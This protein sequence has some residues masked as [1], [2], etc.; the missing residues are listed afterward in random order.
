[1]KTR[2]ARVGGAGSPGFENRV[3][4]F[5][6][7]A[8]LVIV[9]DAALVEHW[10]E[11]IAKHVADAR[12]GDRGD[13]GAPASLRVLAVGGVSAADAAAMARE[14]RAT[15]A[16]SETAADERARLDDDSEGRFSP[17]LSP[18][19]PGLTRSKHFPPAEALA[20]DFDVVVSTFAHMSQ[21]PRRGAAPGSRD[22]LLRVHFLRLIV[23]EG[24]LLGS[25]GS[26]TS[27]LARVRAI[28]AERRWIMTGTPAGAGT[29]AAAESAT[30]SGTLASRKSHSSD[31][32]FSAAARAS[33]AAAAPHRAAAALHP[34]LDLIRAAPFGS[35]RALWHDA[36]A[37]P[38]RERRAEGA[39]ALRA[40]LTRLVVRASKAELGL[41]PPLTRRAVSVPFSPSHARSFNRLANLVRMNLLLADWN[42]PA[43]QESLLHVDRARYAAELYVNV[44]KACCVAGAVDVAPRELDLL[45]TLALICRKR[46]W[47]P[48]KAWDFHL[49]KTDAGAAPDREAP[50]DAI[51]RREAHSE[52]PLGAL[53]TAV[54]DEVDEVRNDR[55][56]LVLD[57]ESLFFLSPSSRGGGEERARRTEGE[58]GRRAGAHLPGGAVPGAS[59]P[60]LPDSHPLRATE[61]VM[62]GGGPCA[63]CGD[64]T[65]V[66]LAPPCGCGAVCPGCA[67]RGGP[68]RC[69]ACGEAYA[70][71]PADDPAR[72]AHNDRP[73][74]AVPVELIEWQPAYA[75]RGAVGHRGG[76][77]APDWERTDSSKVRWVI[78]RLRR[79][80]AAPPPTKEAARE[81]EAGG[82]VARASEGVARASEGAARA[83]EGWRA[84]RKAVVFSAF[85]EHLHLARRAL[86]ETGVPFAATTRSSR[87]ESKARALERFRSDP[88]CG[89]LL[90]DQSGVVGLDL[91]FASLVIAMEPVPDAGVLAQL[92]ARAHRV[93]QTAPVEVEVLAMAGCAA[94]EAMLATVDP[95]RAARAVAEA[96]SALEGDGEESADAERSR[97]RQCLAL[98]RAV[99]VPEE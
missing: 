51:A 54:P 2:G 79:A 10:V 73:K 84:S 55:A 64:E 12:D 63:A 44:R 62:R 91:S 28:R 9:P 16:A 70:T 18:D 22:D 42:D 94:E 48:P 26:E 90:M 43:H 37:R 1:M 78:E 68:E 81:T 13:G 33:D 24:H 75:G 36:V 3:R 85:W 7:P 66:S 58:R 46:G 49:K 76:R 6:S 19:P 98:V 53:S 30:D 45:E 32:T 20:R 21:P 35:S 72:R 99:E 89:V 25:S 39:R 67:E 27:R 71:Q 74:W 88:A 8:T 38:L 31:Y 29:A 87:A 23:D 83:S 59:P 15:A 5:L 50:R 61:D 95:A 60:W 47:E 86:A 93:G 52:T 97:H 57:G 82:E 77:W 96:A 14:R 40:A 34:L 4:V 92:E 56:S 17:P 41:L 80:G 11:Q 65:F 69:V